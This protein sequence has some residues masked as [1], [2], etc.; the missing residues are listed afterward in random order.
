[1]TENRASVQSGRGESGRAPQLLALPHFPSPLSGGSH[2]SG[3]LCCFWGHYPLGCQSCHT[4]QGMRMGEL[5]PLP[6]ALGG[7]TTS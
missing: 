6:P 1:M 4:N 7:R 2:P 3:S 5:P